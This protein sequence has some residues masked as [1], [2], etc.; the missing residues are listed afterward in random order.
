MKL[1]IL[2]SNFK[3]VNLSELSLSELASNRMRLNLAKEA[4]LIKKYEIPQLNFYNE[5]EKVDFLLI[6]KFVSESGSKSFY[7]DDGTR[8]E[9][10]C[11]YIEFS[12]ENN[13]KIILDYTDHLLIVQ[14]DRA[15]FY[16]RILPYV[17]IVVTPSLKMKKNI[18]S[19]YFGKV[20][21]IEDPIEIE[22]NN[23]KNDSYE[24]IDALWFGHNVN[25]VYL[26]NFIN[27]SNKIN[28][29][30]IVTNKLINK[31]KSFIEKLNK[32]IEFKFIEWELDF[33]KK[34]NL[35]CNICLIPSDISD[36]KKNGVS[37]NRLITAFA[38]GLLPVA[39]VVESYSEYRNNFINIDEFQSYNSI[40]L[41]KFN[42]KLKA[43]QNSIIEKYTKIKIIDKWNK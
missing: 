16:N 38:L 35:N 19:Y 14:D 2:A 28:K 11:K 31:D 22:I 12:K 17:D 18:S 36:E 27:K 15:K 42:E 33:Y 20:E 30:K 10:W 26:L 37:N 3:T 1:G 8:L 23:V 24:Q 32:E 7:D 43:N 13:T 34:N 40:G 5:I 39:T 41:Q 4:A 9:K 6:G 29:L 25:L 21:I